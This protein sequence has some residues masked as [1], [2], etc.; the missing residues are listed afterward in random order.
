MPRYHLT[1]FYLATGMEGAP[2]VSDYGI[3][4]AATPEEAKRVAA[5]CRHPSMSESDL[6]WTMGCLTAK[7]VR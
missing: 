4:D 5:R 6:Q 3:V 1:Y 2:D 7:L